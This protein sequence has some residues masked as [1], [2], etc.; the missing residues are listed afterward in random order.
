MNNPLVSIIMPVKNRSNYIK[1]AL[2]EI[3]LQDVNID[4]ID[5]CA[6]MK[7]N[8]LEIKKLDFVSVNRRIH[9]TNFGRTHKE[10]EYQDYASILRAKLKRKAA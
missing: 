10:K 7:E 5:W 3:K 9:N 4:I 1:E 8:N 2:E 6:K